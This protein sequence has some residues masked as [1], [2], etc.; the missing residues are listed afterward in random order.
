MSAIG[1]IFSEKLACFNCS[2]DFD[3]KDGALVCR[4][5]SSRY[6]LARNLISFDNADFKS[7]YGSQYKEDVQS[8]E[9]SHALDE[10][11]SK[12]IALAV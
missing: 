4:Q 10:D 9:Q 1:Q 8:Y 7:Q 11:F 2:G 5:C 6:F 3:L 12:G